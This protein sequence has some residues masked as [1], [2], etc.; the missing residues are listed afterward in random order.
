MRADRDALGNDAL[1]TYVREV[2]NRGR[3]PLMAGAPA[4]DGPCNGIVGV[5]MDPRADHA[6]ISDRDATAAAVDECVRADPDVGSD[7]NV[8]IEVAQ[9]VDA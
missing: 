6:V 7:A 8:S 3:S 5:D 4:R 2:S 1:G 9:V